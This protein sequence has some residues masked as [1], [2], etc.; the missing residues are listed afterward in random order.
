MKSQR[1]RERENKIEG[2]NKVQLTRGAEVACAGTV[3]VTE[4]I[5]LALLTGTTTLLAVFARFG[6]LASSADSAFTVTRI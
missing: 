1:E 4:L 6:I 5:F 2:A 3:L